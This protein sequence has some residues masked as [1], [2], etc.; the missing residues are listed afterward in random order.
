MLVKSPIDIVIV[1]YERYA[2]TS[3]ML[4]AIRKYTI[5]IDYRIIVID[6]GSHIDV[7]KSLTNDKEK[8][9]I[10]IL[11]LLDKNYGLEPAK[12]IGLSLVHSDWYVDTDNDCIP[13]PPVGGHSWLIDLL[14]LK[15]QNPAYLAIS[16]PPQVFIGADK[17]EMFKGAPEVLERKFVGGSLRLM[18]TQAVRDVKGWRNNPTN[19]TE[20]NRGEEHYICGKLIKLG[21]NEGFAKVGYAR[22]VE[23]FH[24]FGEEN[25]GYP[26]AVEH[27]H[28][29]QWPIPTDKMFGSLSGWLKKY[30]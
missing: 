3:A 28:R 27:Y 4:S 16:C 2:F 23:C 18:N 20:A 26:Q 15:A 21:Y 5:D 9:Y 13:R 17:K 1:S 11:V 22:D 6:N 7:H 8:G 30:E 12:N 24:L 29:P 19:M 14:R 10:D 25:W